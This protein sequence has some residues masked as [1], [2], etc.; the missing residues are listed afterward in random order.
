MPNTQAG[1]FISI[2]TPLGD[3]VLLLRKFTGDEGISQ[4]FNFRLCSKVT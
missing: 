4:L 2:T 1:Q 3:D